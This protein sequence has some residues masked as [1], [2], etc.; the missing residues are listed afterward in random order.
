MRSAPGSLYAR[1]RYLVVLIA[2]NLE[3]DSNWQGGLTESDRTVFARCIQ[4]Y[5]LN[6]DISNTKRS[7]SLKSG[8]HA[9]TVGL[10]FVAK[11]SLSS[12]QASYALA[13]VCPQQDSLKTTSALAGYTSRHCDVSLMEAFAI[14]TVSQALQIPVNQ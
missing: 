6:S 5:V 7:T 3:R 10:Q 9:V 2:S 13:I 1:V 14:A 8:S 4:Y 11:M 12:F